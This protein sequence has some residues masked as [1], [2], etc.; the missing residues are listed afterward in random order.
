[1]SDLQ[2]N[3]AFW[4]DCLYAVS[5]LCEWLYRHKCV[6]KDKCENMISVQSVSGLLMFS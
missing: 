6:Y 3:N 5:M 1:M 4:N 2:T